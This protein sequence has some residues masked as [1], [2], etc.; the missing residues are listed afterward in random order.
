MRS[1]IW[2]GSS[3][4]FILG[5]GRVI[6]VDDRVKRRIAAVVGEIWTVGNLSVSMSR[7]VIKVTQP[8]VK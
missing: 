1:S 7:L 3:F 6:N 8:I 4:T 2:H 5:H